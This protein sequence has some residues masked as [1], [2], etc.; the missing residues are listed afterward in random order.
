MYQ[1]KKKLNSVLVLKITWP[2]DVL[3]GPE[4]FVYRAEH[5]WNW[6][7]LASE[8]GYSQPLKPAMTSS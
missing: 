7:V 8:T 1:R 4:L 3:I 6:P 2:F 5:Q